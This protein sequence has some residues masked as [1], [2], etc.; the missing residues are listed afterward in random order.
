VRIQNPEPS[1]KAEFIAK[2]DKQVKDL[3]EPY[4]RFVPIAMSFFFFVAL[5]FVIFIL[6]SIPIL[7]LMLIIYILIRLQV[8]KVRTEMR[9]VQRLT[10]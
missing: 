6:G 2:F 10:I 4:E 9:E 3:I 5:D 7:L 8:I 1:T